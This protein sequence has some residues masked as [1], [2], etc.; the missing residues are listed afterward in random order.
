[1]TPEERV[2]YRAQITALLPEHTHRVGL[3][4]GLAGTTWTWTT[5]AGTWSTTWPSMGGPSL[6]TPYGDLRLHGGSAEATYRQ[7]VGVLV[8]LGGIAA[9]VDGS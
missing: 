3:M 1:M 9:E 5:P 8:A 2:D 6:S 7:F 4:L